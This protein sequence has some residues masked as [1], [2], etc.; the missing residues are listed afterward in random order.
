MLP[1]TLSPAQR[2]A[3]ETTEGPVCVIAGPGAGKTRTL[4]HRYVYL[5]RDLGVNPQNILCVT[6]T[7]KAAQEMKARIRAMTGDLDLGQICTFHAFCVRFLRDEG[8]AVGIPKDFVVIDE[9]DE[10]DLLA[11]VYETFAIPGN[12]LKF[13]AAMDVIGN[14]KDDSNYV[15]DLVSTS[16]EA[17]RAKALASPDISKKVFYGYLWSERKIFGF[18]F[19]DVIWTTFYILDHFESVRRRWQER[20]QYIMV[21]EY[22][23]V[24]NDQAALANLLSEVNKNLFVVGDPDQT[25]YTWRG[26]SPAI[27]L[28]FPKSHPHCRTV[29]L[30]EN[31]RSLP[32]IVLAANSLISHNR[33]R[34]PVA[35]RPVR[36]DSDPARP[37]RVVYDGE[38]T[39]KEALA[40]LVK[41]LGYLHGRGRGWEEFAVLYRTRQSSRAVEEALVKAGIPYRVWSGVAFYARREVKD[42]LCYIRMMTRADDAAFMRTVNAPK[43]GFGPKKAEALKAIAR[44]EGATLYE[45]LLGHIGEKPF[46]T[47]PL[48]AYVEAMEKCRA[49]APG[50]RVSD[51]FNM[52]MA[53]SGYEA[54]LQLSGEDERLNN[55]AELRQA[56]AQYESDADSPDSLSEFLQRASVFAED[57]GEQKGPAMKLMTIHA[58]K[59]LEFPV[60]YV[61]GFSEGILPSA[62]TSTVEE[63]EEERRVAY[64]AMTRAK[65]LLVLMHAQGTTEGS[66][67]RY[68][69]R[70]F[71]ELDRSQLR[72][73]RPLAE[74]EEEAA[75]E[76]LAYKE[77]FL[78]G[79]PEKK[80]WLAP[81]DR[82]RHKVFGEGE[83]LQ[84]EKNG[85]VSIRFEKLATPRTLIAGAPL[86][87]LDGGRG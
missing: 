36:A 33:D 47:K 64:V 71:F 44:A 69:S 25:I 15:K 43:R 9:D 58:A 52:V 60:V 62:R 67:F 87:K 20:L 57:I 6:F 77:R 12:L 68:P 32:S 70:F 61:W 76:A 29:R 11:E 31:Y 75:R 82:V 35:G 16:P 22:Q 24:S 48:R 72:L 79:E 13:S 55:I 45:A 41:S 3:V 7:N 34:F 23:D 17:L 28:R 86:E 65:D 2:E 50:R 5:V 21:D 38:K 39:E 53:E 18:D 49:A 54:A 63:M 42:A 73:V 1:E 26:S 37:T 66:A 81:G 83:V 27:M 74:G 8:Y 46:A 78:T 85:A 84:V 59:G 14:F 30:L 56:I 4:T 19:D 80:S 40:W 51:V 10:A